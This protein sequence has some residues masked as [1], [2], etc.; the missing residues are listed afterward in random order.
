MNPEGTQA[1]QYLLSGSHHHSLPWALRNSVWGHVKKAGYWPQIAKMHRKRMILVSPDS[2]I[3]P[4]MCLVIQ[5]CLILYEPM[6]SSLPGSSSMWILQARIL[7]WVV[8][9]YSRGSF[10]PKDQTQV[11]HIAGGFFYQLSNQGRPKHR[12]TLHSLTWYLVFL[13]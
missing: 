10:Q 9:P 7:E 12:K 3:F 13:N 5:S 11:S 2:C 6:D 4:Y 1:E 8:M